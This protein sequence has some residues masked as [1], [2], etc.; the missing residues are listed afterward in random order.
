MGDTRAVIARARTSATRLTYSVGRSFLERRGALILSPS[1]SASVVS[2]PERSGSTSSISGRVVRLVEE[3]KDVLGFKSEMVGES[4]QLGSVEPAVTALGARQDGSFD[5]R[6]PPELIHRELD[7]E[8][9]CPKK[10]AAHA[11]RMPCSTSNDDGDRNQNVRLPSQR[12]QA[13]VSR[14]AT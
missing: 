12:R 6:T 5:S 3:G 14:G 13:P 4:S 9:P 2:K 1:V 8:A 11:R 7:L 10:R